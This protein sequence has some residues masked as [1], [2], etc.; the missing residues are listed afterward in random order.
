MQSMEAL[1][2]E[3]ESAARTRNQSRRRGP[4]GLPVSPAGK[5]F[6]RNHHCSI[7]PSLKALDLRRFSWWKR[8][9]IFVAQAVK[10]AEPRLMNHEIR[11]R[12]QRKTI[13]DRAQ[14]EPEK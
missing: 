14:Q 9:S 11:T 5:R 1:G 13:S 7:K 10:P 4:A 3:L 2:N 8:H 6:L 12:G